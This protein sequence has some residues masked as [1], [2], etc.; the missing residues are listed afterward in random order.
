MT[1]RSASRIAQYL[2]R[3]AEPEIE[4]VSEMAHG[5]RHLLVIPVYKERTDFIERLPVTKDTLLVL[6]VNQPDTRAMPCPA[7]DEIWERI[8]GFPEARCV[9]GQSTDAIIAALPGSQATILAINRFRGK[10]QIPEHQGVGLARKIGCDLGVALVDHGQLDTAWLCTTDAD[11][12]LPTDYFARLPK[13]HHETIA[14]TFPFTHIGE[15]SE[16]LTATKLYEA[17]IRHYFNGLQWANSP[18][19]FHTIGSCIAV[20]INGYCAVRGYPKRAAAED[21]YMLNKLAKVGHISVLS[22]KP[23]QLEARTSNRAPFGTGPAVQKILA[24]QEITSIPLFYAPQV[25][26]HVKSTLEEIHRWSAYCAVPNRLNFE[27]VFDRWMETVNPTLRNCL[28]NMG[29]RSALQHGWEQSS[30]ASVFIR[31]LMQWF[32][33]FRTR[34]L[35]HTLRDT[36]HPDISYRELMTLTFPWKSE[37][38]DTF[39][40]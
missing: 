32:D 25:F 29:F 34:K 31:H 17:S 23:I 40:D 10:R 22:G 26:D 39:S 33:G 24:R 30:A 3:Y 20:T 38:A 1:G 11:A 15:R 27:V 6:V 14:C 9:H 21:F 4:L 8:L 12:L 28:Q 35:I 18:Y 2:S 7:N 37:I 16:T 19:A 36:S 13:M 5:Y